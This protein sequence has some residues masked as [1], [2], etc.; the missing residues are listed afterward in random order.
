MPPTA[1]YKNGNAPARTTADPNLTEFGNKVAIPPHTARALGSFIADL[2][3]SERGSAIAEQMANGTVATVIK[4]AI[5][6]VLVFQYTRGLA[7][8]Y[9]ELKPVMDAY[10]AAQAAKTQG[11]NN[12]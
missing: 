7:T 2:E 11:E 10:K 8:V 1:I 4:G 9:S 3:T 5:A 6:A 12:A